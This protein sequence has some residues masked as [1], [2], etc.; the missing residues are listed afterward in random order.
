M[1]LNNRPDP[2]T[3]SDCRR[4]IVEN[5]EFYDYRWPIVENHEFY[6]HT[7]IKGRKK[8]AQWKSTKHAGNLRREAR[9]RKELRASRRSSAGPRS[10]K[11]MRRR[12]STEG[13]LFGGE[14][15]IEKK[16]SRPQFTKNIF[17]KIRRCSVSNIF[18]TRFNIFNLKSRS[19]Q[20]Q[21][22]KYI[23]LR[24][25]QYCQGICSS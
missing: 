24:L 19:C 16:K 12:S 2:T 15:I 3:Y 13:S 1:I 14:F 11:A 22:S 21:Y 8:K 9:G 5:H 25:V 17:E 18:I 7:L 23:V 10:T 6:S 4:P 20:S